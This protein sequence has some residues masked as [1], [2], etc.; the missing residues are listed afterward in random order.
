MKRWLY[1][2][3]D[4]AAVDLLR[5]ECGVSALLAR[6]L[7]Q[8]GVANP[9]TAHRFLSPSLDR[10]HDPYRMFGMREAVERLQR[11]IAQQEKILVY[12]DYDVDGTTAI[13]LLR[14]AIQLAGGQ[15]EFHVPHR[16]HEGYGMRE[17]II[18]RA[19]RDGVRLLVS[20]D[21]G[22]R[23]AEVVRRAGEL[24]I[25]TIVTDH[26]LPETG[27]P[28]ALAVLNPNQP[29]CGYP[30]K[31]LCG[32]GVAFK[33][34]Q[35]LLS[36][37][38]WTPGR[39]ER[40]LRSFLKLVAI[41]TIADMVPL[42]G[43][44]RIFA[45]VGLDALRKPKQA[46]LRALLHLAGAGSSRPVAAGRIA[47]QIAPRLNAAGRM[48]TARLVVELFTTDDPERAQKLAAQLN[49]LNRER[50]EAEQQ[51]VDELVERLGKI[52]S[53]DDLPFLV[54]EGE[55]WHPG[56]IGI[57]ASRLIERFHRPTLVLSCDPEDGT[58]TGSGRSIPAFHLLE[59]LESARELFLRFGGHRQAAGCT[60]PAEK[61]PELRERLNRYAG[62]ALRPEDFI[63]ALQLDAELAFREI[64]D[65][66]MSQLARLEPHGLG[67]P[68]PA[69]STAAVK[70]AAPPRLLKERHLKLQM[71]HENVFLP[72][73][74]WRMGERMDGLAQGTLLD[75]AYTVEQDNYWGGWQ[76]VLA[77]FRRPETAQP[78]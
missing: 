45:K 42:Q 4:P 2:K 17:E 56:V 73:M 24:G 61:I 70:L 43:E 16:I 28:P 38:G 21:T 32:A 35:A 49:A 50:Q 9:E 31:N 18:E 34:S 15:A 68:S 20:V 54:L 6:L 65:Q 60:L 3:F 72:G 55:G 30:D 12:G 41:G 77:D 48:D 76:L 57:V 67:N 19:A 44:N 10:L 59:S 63:P 64:T 62:A 5:R 71:E 75:A 58:A 33:L 52:P 13:V 14:T 39:L 46:G 8:R 1:R 11:A 23:E 51:I 66:T 29:G 74:G 36:G 47:F 69:F 53:P 37:L 78:A 40:V 27:L 25:D 22:I 26:H 7:V